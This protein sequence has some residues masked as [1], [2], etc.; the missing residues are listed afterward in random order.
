[1]LRR[2][3]LCA[4]ALLPLATAPVQAQ[5][6]AESASALK[7]QIRDWVAATLGPSVKLGPDIPI[8]ITAEGDHY[9]IAIPLGDSAAA[10]ALTATARERTQDRWTIDSI[11]LPSPA[12]FHLT[13]PHSAGD[14]AGSTTYKLT[15]GQQNGTILFDPTFTTATTSTSSIQDMDLQASGRKLQ[16]SS[17]LDRGAS[18]TVLRPAA[19]GRVDMIV[20]SSLEGYRITSTAGPSTQPVKV[21]VGKARLDANVD[22]VSRERLAQLVQAVAQLG[23][24]ASG[25]TTVDRAGPKADGTSPI[26]S[27]AAMLEILADLLAGLS[28]DETIE[29]L[30]VSIEGMD[31]S[32]SNARL[33]FA[34]KGESGMIQA[35]LDLG[36]EGLTLPD[37]GLGAMADLIPT[38]FALRPVVSGVPIDAI[39][40]LAKASGDGKSPDRAD[41]AALF[42]KGGITAGLESFTIGVAGADFTGNG[43]VLFTSPQVFGGT[44][45]VSATNLDLLQQRIASDP[46]LAQAVPGI[47]FL[48]GIGRTVQ[49]RMVW[50]ITYKEGRLLVNNQ[51]LSALAGG[52]KGK[53]RPNRRQ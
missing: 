8:Q 21:A 22:G 5:V 35:R 7:Q 11:R 34:A 20:D 16:Q 44:A 49:N 50:D 45:Q 37:L 3:A 2:A 19:N 6:T 38:R 41:I 27:S 17:H 51:D 12:E 18:N 31:G 14:M 30:A 24:A 10:P 52:P 26:P 9:A 23:A 25:A 1:M 36:A 33:G 40:N 39:K 46:N 29:N 4:T 47:I 42:D 32:L 53:P 15:I 48:K 28:F 13:L 43:S